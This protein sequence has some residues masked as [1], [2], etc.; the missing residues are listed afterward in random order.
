MTDNE[1]R[2][3]L[4][5]IATSHAKQAN[6]YKSH[7]K[8]EPIN[9]GI[10]SAVPISRVPPADAPGIMKEKVSPSVSALIVILYWTVARCHVETVDGDV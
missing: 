8:L 5:S 4:H 2:E 10:L 3:N 9:P 7:S 6:T 1:G